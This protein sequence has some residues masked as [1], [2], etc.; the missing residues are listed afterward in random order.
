MQNT[1]SQNLDL[2]IQTV[3]GTALIVFPIKPRKV[4]QSGQVQQASPNP[5]NGLRL[6]YH[7]GKTS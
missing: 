6:K 5:Q 3:G 2:T 7:I 1:Q 4:S